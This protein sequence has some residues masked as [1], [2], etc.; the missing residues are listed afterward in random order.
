MSP[1]A[2]AKNEV[3]SC[4]FENLLMISVE[5]AFVAIETASSISANRKTE[6][7]ALPQ[8]VGRVI[9]KE[10]FSDVDSP[11]HN[12]S[13]MDGFAVQAADIAAG[14]RDFRV[15]ETI[16]AGKLPNQKVIAGTTSRIMTGAPLPE[17]ADS[18][19]MIE[20]ANIGYSDPTP[21]VVTLS[22]TLPFPKG[23]HQMPRAGNFARGQLI[24]SVG[25]RIRPVDVGLLAE[26]G[27][28]TVDVYCRTR[29]S[30]LPTGDELVD[31]RSVPAASQIRN[32]N[33]PMIT[34]IASGWGCD[35][36]EL[37]IGIDNRAALEAK[38]DEGLQQDVM[39]LS[40]GVSAGT[41]DLVPEVLASMGVEQIFHKVKVK[42]GK[43]IFFGVLNGPTRRCLVFGLP[44]NPVSSLV[45]MHLFVSTAVSILSGIPETK[46]RPPRF[47]SLL[48]E[49]HQTRGDRPTFWPGRQTGK[50]PRQVQPLKWN[51]SSDLLSLRDAEGLIH[52]PVR[53]TPFGAGDAVKFLPFFPQ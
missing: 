7:V 53:E 36:A 21:D 34:A 19:V 4:K 48:T 18:I 17:G 30:V 27:A 5:E 15:L 11:P 51:G 22:V 23:R 8:S 46:A 3:T 38:I 25:H 1:V 33:G 45:G 16:V 26:I 43:P 50:D 37:G 13:V 52:F 24:F 29:V 28:A 20:M 9:A 41:M 31:C 2:A 40:G 44:G 6:T 47:E 35:V 49:P 39:I 12:K 32:S 14:V 42:P 10:V